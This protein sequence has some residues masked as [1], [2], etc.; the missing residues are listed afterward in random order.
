M[1]PSESTT[2][3]IHDILGQTIFVPV[4]GACWKVDIFVGGTLEADF[5]DSHCS[6]PDYM[7]SSTNGTFSLFDS[8]NTFDHT[9]AF[10]GA[11]QGF[12]G[13]MAF[14]ESPNLVTPSLKTLNWTSN[15]KEYEVQVSLP[16]CTVAS[17]VPSIVPMSLPCSIKTFLNRTLHLEAAGGCWQVQLFDGGTLEADFNNN[18]CSNSTFV[19]SGIFSLFNGSNEDVTKAIFIEGPMGF[20]GTFEFTQSSEVM[21]AKSVIKGWNSSKKEFAVEVRVSNCIQFSNN[22]HLCE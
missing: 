3:N 1:L 16:T 7:F 12:S 18:T 8:I 22:D 9:V 11:S 13:T 15:T 5:T 19:S 4:A 6:K 14:N 17:M 10:I 2:C 20:S 21:T